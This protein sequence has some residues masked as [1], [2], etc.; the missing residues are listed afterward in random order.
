MSRATRTPRECPRPRSEP[1]DHGFVAHQRP[2]LAI[3]DRSRRRP[4][5][6]RRRLPQTEPQRLGLS[7]TQL[8]V[9]PYLEQLI[10]G[11]AVHCEQLIVVV[12][13]PAADPR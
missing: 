9:A 11:I 6:A 10:G 1:N 13:R 8:R 2:Q 3:E 12:I 5:D 4:D 7:L